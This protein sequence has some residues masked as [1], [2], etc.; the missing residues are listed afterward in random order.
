MAPHVVQKKT[1]NLR[2][3]SNLKTRGK[4]LQGIWMQRLPITHSLQL[5]SIPF[6]NKRLLIR[7][8]RA[9]RKDAWR[10]R[11][12]ALLAKQKMIEER[13]ERKRNE[14]LAKYLVKSLTKKENGFVEAIAEIV[15]GLVDAHTEYYQELF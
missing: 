1:Y 13:K 6:T 5:S 2:K 4:W 8:R 10:I 11:Q 15:W 14:D 3:E 9:K 7:A 12:K